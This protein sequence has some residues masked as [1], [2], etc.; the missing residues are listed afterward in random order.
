MNAATARMTRLSIATLALAFAT[1]LALSGVSRASGVTVTDLNNGAT[2]AGLAETLVGG[3]VSISNATLTG[4]SRS[5]GTFTG[6]AASVGFESGIVMSSGKVQTYPTDE[7][8]SR[9]VEGPN[10]CYEATGGKPEGPSGWEN[11]TNFEMPGDAELT[12]LSGF[13]TYDASVLEFDFVPQHPTVQFSYVFSSEEYSDY[14]NTPYNDVFAFFVNGTNCALVPGGN[15]AVSVNT[16][17]NGNDVEGGDPT[18]HH[19]EL[20]RD[21]VRPAPTIASQMDGLTTMLTCTAT[22]TPG[23]SNHMKLAISD[24]SDQIFDSAVFIQ[25]KS[26]VSGTQLST[27]L[28]GGG[29]A[30]ETLTVH[31]GTAVSDH[32]LL[33]GPLAPSATGT[34]QYSVYSDSEC[35]N[36]VAGAGSVAL[37]GGTAPPSAAQTLPLGTY[38]WQASYGGDPNNNASVSTC[39]S[40]VL[41]VTSE[42]EEEPEGEADPTTIQTSLW[43]AGRSGETLNVPE[44]TAVSDRATLRGP[45]AVEATGTVSY[46]AY[47]DPA[48]TK[49]VAGAGTSAVASGVV[50]PS[51]PLTL[52]PG[53][54]YWQASYSGDSGNLPSKS[55]CGVEVENVASEGPTQQAPEFGRCVKVAK[56]A[57]AFGSATCTTAGGNKSYSWAPGTV[58]SHFTTRLKG[59]SATIETTKAFKV[60]CTGA[61]GT[62]DYTGVK[63]VGNVLLTFTGCAHAGIRCQSAGA[64]EGELRTGQLAGALGVIKL[65]A[66]AAKNTIGID[67]Y[68]V[69]GSSTLA[70]FACGAN[71]ASIRGSVLVPASAN[72]MLTS[73][74]LAFKET[75]GH[76]SP[77]AF[78]G[79]APDVLEMSL[80][81]GTFGQSGLKATL[82]QTGE[83]PVE[84]SSVI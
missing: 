51:S 15:E 68:P 8:C 44:G 59:A 74:T 34:V 25:A 7:A 55:A 56:G 57:G 64:G 45:N 35:K 62:G 40:E 50:Q 67:L 76:Q 30:G 58:K 61:S 12:L 72:K 49:L 29:R 2:P 23:Q 80:E 14:S 6:G 16:I 43:G 79:S 32:A 38:Y 10:T 69:Q 65:G 13:P 66:S 33:T 60:T 11:S 20:F 22:V 84:V 37:A 48:C 26:L 83:E 81:G 36:L 24:A 82:T 27:T 17:N 78:L 54:Y 5:A 73:G 31:Q 28:T 19:P 41:H 39:G 53:T 3:G 21:N 18:P 77:E 4:A 46:A 75:K 63:T 1:T 9:G 70:D 47:S 52:S 71:T 42:A